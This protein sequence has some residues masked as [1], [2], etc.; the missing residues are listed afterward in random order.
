M[1][2]QLDDIRKKRL[3]E[4]I[5]QARSQGSA[6]KPGAAAPSAPAAALVGSPAVLFLLVGQNDR[7]QEIAS[8][9]CL[10]C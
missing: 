6:P 4:L 10:C 3:E 1:I 5:L 8:S 9:G 7:L 2:D